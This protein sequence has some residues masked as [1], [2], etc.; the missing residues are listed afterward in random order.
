LST[1]KLANGKYYIRTSI[2]DIFDQKS[3]EIIDPFIVGPATGIATASVEDMITF[4][5]NPFHDVLN[6]FFKN[7]NKE[8]LTLSL[9]DVT[10]RTILS[11]DK[12]TEDDQQLFLGNIVNGVYFV[13][14]WNKSQ[15]TIQRLK[16]IKE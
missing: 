13:E 12:V 14:V 2:T 7:T 5:P 10:G 8:E 1:T 3:N 15:N 9:Y 11:K 4:Y 16:L 6:L